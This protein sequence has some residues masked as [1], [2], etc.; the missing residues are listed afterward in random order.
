VMSRATTPGPVSRAIRYIET[1]LPPDELVTID[2]FSFDWPSACSADAAQFANAQA[3]VSADF[4]VQLRVP[5][6]RSPVHNA[7]PSQEAALVLP[8]EAM[9]TL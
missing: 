9:L 6:S 2:A 5:T 4:G 8:P 3:T 7:L 1:P